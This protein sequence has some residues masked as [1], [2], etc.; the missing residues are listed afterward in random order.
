MP[1]VKAMA[2]KPSRW[3]S[4]SSG[5]TSKAEISNKTD[6]EWQERRTKKRQ[7]R[8]IESPD[9]PL[10]RIRNQVSEG[11]ENVVTEKR[12]KVKEETLRIKEEAEDVYGR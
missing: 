3:S 7:D 1:R 9:L 8:L 5:K 11:Q 4:R 6:S 12:Q 10:K 2:T